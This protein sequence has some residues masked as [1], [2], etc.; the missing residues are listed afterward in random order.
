MSTQANEKDKDT[1]P[2][3]LPG[4]LRK[5]WVLGVI[6]LVVA[7]LLAWLAIAR[8]GDDTGKG[9]G[10]NPPSPPTVVTPPTSHSPSSKPAGQTTPQEAPTPYEGDDADSLIE[11]ND[12]PP[13]FE[14]TSDRKPQQGDA[15]AAKQALAAVLPSWASN[16]FSNGMSMDD[17]G[18]TFQSNA[19]SSS[20]FYNQSRQ[21]FNLLWNG[22]FTQGYRAEKATLVSRKELWNVGS[23]S[24]WRVTIKR[25]LAPLRDN[26]L[27]ASSEELTWDFLIRQD[28]PGGK[29][30]LV[31]FSDPLAANE[32]PETFY[33]PAEYR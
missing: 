5:P 2:S 13:G 14:P 18:R 33:L 10:T 26:G 17:W 30:V 3:W 8:P 31:A 4:P 12:G 20:K 1:L 11:G 7:A 24:L 28:V 6:M 16:S 32:K 19:S 15:T 21:S 22:A 27:G 9:M 25:D 29:P 23:H